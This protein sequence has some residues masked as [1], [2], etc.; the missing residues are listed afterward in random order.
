MDT[1]PRCDVFLLDIVQSACWSFPSRP[2]NFLFDISSTAMIPF[3]FQFQVP[4]TIVRE[5]MVWTGLATSWFLA[6]LTP[7][8]P[9]TTSFFAAYV[10]SKV[11]PMDLPPDWPTGSTNNTNRG[12]A[13]TAT[14]EERSRSPSRAHASER[15]ATVAYTEGTT[16]SSERRGDSME[17]QPME[18]PPAEDVRPAVRPEDEPPNDQLALEGTGQPLDFSRLPARLPVIRENA[19]S[20]VRGVG[21]SYSSMSDP[22]VSPQAQAR[23]QMM[24]SCFPIKVKNYLMARWSTS[25]WR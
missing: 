1:F 2:G 3:A 13:D 25:M 4:R 5:A 9:W 21:S 17:P 7:G 6:S 24:S 10:E 16:E 14:R 22:V 8:C 12:T 11:L 20:E 23:T 18:E 15:S 19:E